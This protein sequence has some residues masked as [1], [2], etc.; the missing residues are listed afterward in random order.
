MWWSYG[1]C[2]ALGDLVSFVQFQKREKHPWR[3]VNF[4][5]VAGLKSATFLKSTL[6]H[7]CF[8]RVLNSTNGT[9]LRNVSHMRFHFDPLSFSYFII[10]GYL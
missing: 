5:K 2:G 3:S 6:L 8:S 4:R 7:G 10:Y 1:I 9:K